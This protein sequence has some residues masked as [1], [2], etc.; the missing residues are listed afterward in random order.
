[1]RCTARQTPAYGRANRRVRSC[2]RGRP[3]VESGLALWAS[4]CGPPE[5][6]GRAAYASPCAGEQDH[7]GTR[8]RAGQRERTHTSSP[9]RRDGRGLDS[10]LGVPACVGGQAGAGPRRKAA[11]SWGLLLRGAR[12]VS[13]AAGPAQGVRTRRVLGGSGQADQ[14]EQPGCSGGAASHGV[15][16]AAHPNAEQLQSSTERSRGTTG[17]AD[18]Q[19]AGTGAA[20]NSGPP[21]PRAHT[22]IGRSC[23]G[24]RSAVHRPNGPACE[25]ARSGRLAPWH[26][27]L[28]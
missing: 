4:G 6:Q 28:R 16:V 3:G 7:F 12:L 20:R 8:V 17:R 14:T 9:S 27:D 24:A 25:G 11:A 21:E 5:L 19:C 18:R 15:G 2:E 10:G 22:P 1:M 23:A 26:A 13:A